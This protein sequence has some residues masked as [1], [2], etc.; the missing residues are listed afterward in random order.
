M[1][2]K[3][4]TRILE[5][6]FKKIPACEKIIVGRADGISIASFPRDC[7]ISDSIAASSTSITGLSDAATE[8]LGKGEVQY[9]L[10]RA[11][12]GFIL[13]FGMA[14]FNLFIMAG[15]KVNLGLLLLM[16]NKLLDEVAQMVADISSKRDLEEDV[17]LLAR[18]LAESI[19]DDKV[20]I[21]LMLEDEVG[22]A[23]PKDLKEKMKLAEDI[24]NECARQDIPCDIR[25]SI[26]EPAKTKPDYGEHVEL[27]PTTHSIPVKEPVNPQDI[28][29]SEIKYHNET[30]IYHQEPAKDRPEPTKSPVTEHHDEVVLEPT[31]L[32]KQTNGG[33]FIPDDVKATEVRHQNDSEIQHET[34]EFKEKAMQ[35]YGVKHDDH[36][37]EPATEHLPEVDK[38]NP[39]DVKPSEVLHL[40]DSVE[41]HEPTEFEPKQMQDYGKEHDEHTLEPATEHLPKVENVN[42][43][44]VK[45]QF[46]LRHNETP[47][48]HEEPKKETPDPTIIPIS[49]HHDET[50]LEPT[51][52]SKRYDGKIILPDEVKPVEVARMND[53][54][55][56]HE[57]TEFE[58]KLMQD[59]G[60][61]H[62]DHTLEPA[63]EHLPQVDKVNP[64]DVKPAEVQHLNDSVEHNEPIEF[65]PK[66]MQDYGKEHDEHTL[67][68]ATEHLPKVENVNPEDVKSQFVL[69]HNETPIYHEEPKKE[70][71]DP[72]IIPKTEHH[73]ET[74]LEPTTQSIR[75]DGKIVLSEEVKAKDVTL[76]NDSVEHHEPVEFEPK[77]MQDYG[78]EH[79]DHTLEPATE[80][81]PEVDKVNP[82]DVKAEQ[83]TLM[84]ES[85]N[86]EDHESVSVKDAATDESD[87]K[88]YKLDPNVSSVIDKLNKAIDEFKNVEKTSLF[89]PTD[90]DDPFAD[91]DDLTE[92]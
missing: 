48:Y 81:L 31:T 67:E 53:S 33:K 56:S 9:T 70:T 23:V 63:T 17:H 79:D 85:E 22:E 49:E 27:E 10:I 12:K 73:D 55:I 3:Y 50:V 11:S 43:E 90:K 66:Q 44:D 91:K 29:P 51:T 6:T 60:K 4:I 13:V 69:R 26:E 62:D 68:P 76:A 19:G 71:P 40:N 24:A 59:Y 52:Q 25:I 15:K 30:L 89:G 65:E 14:T 28:K 34:V 47:I 35:D 82:E 1:N 18:E 20:Q 57:K 38:V 75:Y 64:E 88:E 16:G 83:V 58:P 61:E 45:S 42:P 41:H 37:L 54:E 36:T 21:E 92:Y 46:V 77:Q 80:H 87:T 84:N 2:D 8:Y 74:I 39:E 78:K 32:T 5:K 7:E 86:H 72:T